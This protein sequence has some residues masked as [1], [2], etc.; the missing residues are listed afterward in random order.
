MDTSSLLHSNVFSPVF[1]VSYIHSLYCCC[2]LGCCTSG[3]RNW[4]LDVTSS[5]PHPQ[6]ALPTSAPHLR[7]ASTSLIAVPQKASPILHSLLPM[8]ASS[9]Q[10]RGKHLLTPSA[11]WTRTSTA[12]WWDTHLLC[13][14]QTHLQKQ[15]HFFISLC[16]LFNLSNSSG[17]PQSTFAI[18]SLWLKQT[19]LHT[20]Q[21]NRLHMV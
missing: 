2:V 18:R 15:V 21:V 10:G 20:K 1:Y 6:V 14:Y 7:S 3:K 4:S 8:S 19:P 11:R 5:R 17:G 9:Y 13:L 16:W 12:A